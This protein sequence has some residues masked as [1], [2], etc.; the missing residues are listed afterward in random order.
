M[1]PQ[2]DLA[3]LVVHSPHSTTQNP[4]STPTTVPIHQLSSPQPAQPKE[5]TPFTALSPSGCTI[6][7]SR[8]PVHSV[9]QESLSWGLQ[10]SQLLQEC[11]QQP[12]QGS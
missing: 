3:L 2:G 12:S 10:N 4:G 11:S 7:L 6:H 1:S 5:C 9:G 8:L